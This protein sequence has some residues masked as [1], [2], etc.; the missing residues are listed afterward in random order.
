MAQIDTTH[1]R[2]LA[3]LRASGRRWTLVACCVAACAKA[4]EPPLWVF[5]EPAVLA[6][7]E[8]WARYNLLMSI[9][10][11]CTL[12]LMLLGGVL[13]DMFGRRRMLLLGL[14]GLTAA[15]ML[16]GLSPEPFWFLSARLL[17]A[18]AGA[19]V[20]PL[21]L[22]MLYIAFRKDFR[23]RTTAIAI[24]ISVTSTAG[25]SAGLLGQFM[26]GLLDWR[27]TLVVP[28][29]FALVGL[30][31]VWRT[32]EES[33]ISEERHFDLIGHASW[34]LTALAALI[35]IS[36]LRV[37]G[38]YTTALLIA[39][40]VGV[41]LGTAAMIWW[42]KQ[43][44]DSLFGQSNLPRRALLVLIVYGVCL[45]IGFIGFVGLVRNVLNAVYGYSPV[46]AAVALA[47]LLAGMA[48]M[49][50][51]GMRRLV[52]LRARL[53][54]SAA[55]A[56]FC[57]VIVLAVLTRAAGFYPWLALL[58][59]AVGAAN[60][61]ANTAWTSIFFTL[62]PRD[63]V[64]V[65]TGIN[66]SVSQAGGAI[67]GALTGGLLVS[68]GLAD[69]LRRLVAAGVESTQIDAAL[70]ALNA[71]LTSPPAESTI[72]PSL[73]QR[74]LAGYQLTFLA[75]Y[76]RVLLIV[77]SITMLGCVVVWFGLPAKERSAPAL[78][79]EADLA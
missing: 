61:A 76:D 51:Y 32:A 18:V 41:V 43:T 73:S 10:T 58:L 70:G 34:A 3:A 71:I 56:A 1:T 5:R 15:H 48:A 64:G 72:D 33:W 46:L 28:I 78:P 24:Y 9:V 50:L 16:A 20:V 4:L 47:P 6:F 59:A 68:F 37:A 79:D 42:D 75:A 30:V 38:A 40:I 52:Y 57:A 12:V 62:V 13:G 25:L 17:S 60:V 66:S 49:T 67:G 65:R 27:T 22:S 14:A 29:V 23:A 2:P 39:S 77:A 45:Q 31:L 8:G 55:L 44:P 53:V 26:Y 7:N 36:V 69:L 35:G 11:L 21:S 54:M 63:A 74:L 19:L